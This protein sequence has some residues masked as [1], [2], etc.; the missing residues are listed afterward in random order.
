MTSVQ[1]EWKLTAELARLDLD[2]N[3]QQ[4]LAREAERMRELFQTMAD[5]DVEDLE[6][7]THSNCAGSRVREDSAVPFDDTDA[8][9]EASPE[10]EDEY[11]LIPNVL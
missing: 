7:T 2:E 8:L 1:D 3:E 5:A 6:P 10:A 11:F 9:I 4:R